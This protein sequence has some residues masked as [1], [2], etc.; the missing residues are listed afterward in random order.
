MTREER[1]KAFI[2]EL[3]VF[4]VE[5]QTYNSIQLAVGS[6]AAQKW[7]KLRAAT[8]IFGYLTIG[9]AEEKLTEFL[10]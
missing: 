8:P 6:K 4:L 7:A 10:S 3:A 1:K 9:E 5:D 2:H